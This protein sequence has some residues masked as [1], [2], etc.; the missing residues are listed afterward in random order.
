MRF[1]LLGSGSRGNAALVEKANT[2]VMVDCGFSTREVERRLAKLGKEPAQLTAILVTHEHSDH[3]RGVGSLARK[4]N[5]PVWM[6]YGTWTQFSRCDGEVPRVNIINSHE[7]FALDD[8]Q[9]T[10]FPMPHDAREPC[11]FVFEDGARKLGILTDAGSY[12]PHIIDQL[13]QCDALQLECNHDVEQLI[14]GSYPPSLKE[15]IRSEMGHLSNA[16]AAGLLDKL[17][18]TRLQ[19]LVAVHLSE[20]HNTPSLAQEAISGVLNCSPD[21][22]S[23]ASQDN[24]LSWRDLA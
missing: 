7:P 17:D 18:T 19:H 12:T 5:V 23:V 10:P 24:G 15:R 8:L 4:H 2:C 21:W 3:I 20:K 11:Q 1:A 9:I 6:T 22:V 13:T 14:N 16:Q